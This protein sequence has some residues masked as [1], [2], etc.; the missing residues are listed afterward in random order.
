MDEELQALYRAVQ[1]DP[2]DF[3][4][5]VALVRLLIRLGR[6]TE[7]EAV[8]DEM[9]RRFGVDA[10]AELAAASGLELIFIITGAVTEVVILFGAGLALP[11]SR[12]GKLTLD[13]DADR[14]KFFELIIELYK[15][16]IRERNAYRNGDRSRSI[17]QLWA[18]ADYLWRLVQAFL[19]RYPDHDSASLLRMIERAAGGWVDEYWRQDDSWYMPEPPPARIPLPT[20][21]PPS[22]CPPPPAE[23]PHTVERPRSY[24]D[25]LKEQAKSEAQRKREHIARIR[26]R[27]RELMRKRRDPAY[28]YEE[29][30]KTID[31]FIEELMKELEKLRQELKEAGED[32]G[33]EFDEPLDPLPPAPLPPWPLGHPVRPY[34]LYVNLKTGRL[35]WFIDPPGSDS[36][37]E[38]ASEYHW[39]WVPEVDP[40]TGKIIWK[41]GWLPGA[42]SGEMRATRLMGVARCRCPKD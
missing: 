3:A 27:I 24:E 37:W 18:D 4:A 9:I 23:H 40:D 28:D 32:T 19:R 6:T 38:P 10:V 2:G 22:R 39:G 26:E 1:A 16:H 25:W 11:A 41:P 7:A 34:R 20:P 30:H 35:D 14:D 21:P 12:W 13:D 17:T 36:G 8:L 5:W 33:E 31:R 29:V 42:S 15:R